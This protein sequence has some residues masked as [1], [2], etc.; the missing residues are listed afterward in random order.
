MSD[1]VQR[2]ADL[3]AIRD[4]PRRYAHYVWQKDADGAAHLF[5]EDGEMDLSDRPSLAGRAEILK[6]YRETFDA[7]VFLPFVHNH[8]IDL[9]G[10]TATGTVYLDLRSEDDGK[11]MTG[12]GFYD[13]RY[14]RTAEGWK[15]SY[16]K[17]NLVE[18]REA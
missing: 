7:N 15:F 5:A 8:V 11:K 9:A 1:D 17:L 10:D 18:Y 4:L 13:D 16:R 6:V 2:L 14:V 12:H 3:E